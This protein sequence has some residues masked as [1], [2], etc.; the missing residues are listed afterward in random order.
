MGYYSFHALPPAHDP[1]NRPEADIDTPEM[2]E[3]ALAAE[4]TSM[5]SRA[6]RMSSRS[7]SAHAGAGSLAAARLA[8]VAATARR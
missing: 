7:G 3:A 6:E 4:R 8:K 2:I 1:R 5:R